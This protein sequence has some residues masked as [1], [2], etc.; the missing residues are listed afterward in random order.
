[1]LSVDNKKQVQV[2]FDEDGSNFWV[3]ADKIFSC[4]M[5]PVGFDVMAMRQETGWNEAATIQSYYSDDNPESRAVGY[6]VQF[7]A[8][9]VISRY[10][11]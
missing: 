5:V 4:E 11:L 8:D 2:R 6:T 9:G 10:Q 1:V 7:H 3:K